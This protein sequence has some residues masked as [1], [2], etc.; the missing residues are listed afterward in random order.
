MAK[1]PRRRPMSDINVVPYI[2]VML[3]LL[4]IFM[5]TAPLM[6][7]GIRVVLPQADSEAIAIEDPNQMLVISINDQGEYFMDMG[8]DDEAVVELELVAERVS[9]I[10]SANP[11][12]KVLVEGD[13]T[14][15]YGRVIDLMD[16][17]QKVGVQ[18]V[19]LITQ[20]PSG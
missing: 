16:R 7:Q 8:G 13:A 19:G 10:T 5:V 9:K 3:V 11:G 17:L 6:T 18:D 12:L 2:D 20:P 1:T 14:I 15:A 4:V